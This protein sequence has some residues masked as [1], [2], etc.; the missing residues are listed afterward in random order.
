M[1]IT[2][3]RS[4]FVVTNIVIAVAVAIAI[5]IIITVAVIIVVTIVTIIIIII[6]VVVAAVVVVAAAVVV[7]SDAISFRSPLVAFVVL[8]VRLRGE[9]PLPTTIAMQR[10]VAARRTR[11]A[12][13]ARARAR[14]ASSAASAFLLA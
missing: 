12:L 11:S 13:G 1:V 6:F 9:Q 5:A 10:A 8:V 4:F 7:V 14:V 2:V 3:C